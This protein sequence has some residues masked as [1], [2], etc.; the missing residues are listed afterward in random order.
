MSATGTSGILKEFQI[1]KIDMGSFSFEKPPPN[2]D[3]GSY[4]ATRGFLLSDAGPIADLD[5]RRLLSYL[6]QEE[7]NK[8]W[9]YLETTQLAEA[10]GIRWKDLGARL[11][12][13]E[14]KLLDYFRHDPDGARSSWEVMIEYK[15]GGISSRSVL[16][17]SKPSQGRQT[18][19]SLSLIPR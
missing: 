6:L 12:S 17:A 19:I 10:S 3:V 1:S 18:C 8:E 9:F 5:D 4:L 11:E 16:S 14:I 2:V 7:N 13:L 15:G